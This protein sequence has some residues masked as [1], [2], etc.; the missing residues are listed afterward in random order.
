MDMDRLGRD[1]REVAQPAA[2]RDVIADE[3][4]ARPDALDCVGNGPADD[5]TQDLGRLADGVGVSGQKH[6]GRARPSSSARGYQS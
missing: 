4:P 6:L 1:E 5:P 2:H 3:P